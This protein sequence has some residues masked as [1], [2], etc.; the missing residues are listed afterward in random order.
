MR[1]RAASSG[2]IIS[3]ISTGLSVA[4]SA[5]RYSV[6]LFP[7][8]TTT[9]SRHPRRVNEFPALFREFSG[10]FPAAI[11]RTA[12]I[13]IR[14][15]AAPFPRVFPRRRRASRTRPRVAVSPPPA[16]HRARRLPRT[17]PGCTAS[18]APSA[19]RSGQGTGSRWGRT[20][21]YTERAA[22]EKINTR[23]HV[24]G[25][26]ITIVLRAVHVMSLGVHWKVYFGHCLRIRPV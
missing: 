12:I 25:T 16:S 2:T 8:Y 22:T 23:H 14:T 5:I 10:Q 11:S 4:I 26:P 3:G 17:A 15:A 18:R 20:Y 19:G 6:S 24:A 7:R 21:T 13:Q 9:L 1:L